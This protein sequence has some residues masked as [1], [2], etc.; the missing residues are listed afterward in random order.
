MLPARALPASETPFHTIDELER[1]LPE[2]DLPAREAVAVA[3]YAGL[4]LAEDSRAHLDRFGPIM[5]AER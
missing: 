4:R 1:V 2:L 3:G 5:M